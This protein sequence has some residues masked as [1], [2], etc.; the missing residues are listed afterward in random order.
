MNPAAEGFDI[1][2]K[3]FPLVLTS[4]RRFLWP[5]VE[6]LCE[7]ANLSSYPRLDHPRQIAEATAAGIPTHRPELAIPGGGATGVDDGHRSCSVS[8]MT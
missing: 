3:A 1:A 6:A 8:T 7:Q 5:R 2:I 4:G